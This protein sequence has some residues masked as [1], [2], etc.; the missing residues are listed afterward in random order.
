MLRRPGEG[1]AVAVA[2]PF[3]SSIEP[4]VQTP[5]DVRRDCPMIAVTMLVQVALAVQEIPDQHGD[6]RPRQHIGREHRHHH[7]QRQRLE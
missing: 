5:D 1:S 7:R 3:K 6:R 4:M 2:K